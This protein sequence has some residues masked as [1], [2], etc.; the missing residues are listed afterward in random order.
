MQLKEKPFLLGDCGV[1]PIQL[2]KLESDSQQPI[3]YIKVECTME[4]SNSVDKDQ[5][6]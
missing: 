1:W 2:V 4:N 5:G 6:V 3:L